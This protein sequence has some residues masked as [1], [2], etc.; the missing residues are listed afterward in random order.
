MSMDYSLTEAAAEIGVSWRTL[1]GRL[2]SLGWLVHVGPRCWRTAAGAVQNGYLVPT[3][4]QSEALRIPV[5]V[6]VGFRITRA[7]IAAYRQTIDKG[8]LQ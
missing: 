4:V 7:G 1:E 2:R 8:Y 5:P 3:I 6:E